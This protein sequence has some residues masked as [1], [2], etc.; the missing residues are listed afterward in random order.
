MV[1]REWRHLQPLQVKHH[2]WRDGMAKIEDARVLKQIVASLFIRRTVHRDSRPHAP[3][4][5]KQP[6]HV[7]HMVVGEQK[8]LEAA[9]WPVVHQM[10]DPRVQQRHRIVKFDHPAT[11]ASTVLR[12]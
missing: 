6:L 11:R 2:E 7:I 3:A 10:R 5:R 1:E 9:C 4:Q 8:L 12:L